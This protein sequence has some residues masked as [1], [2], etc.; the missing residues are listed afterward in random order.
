MTHL[1]DL[2]YFFPIYSQIFT[3]FNFQLKRADFIDNIVF[4]MR[5]ILFFMLL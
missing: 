4:D 3:K 5:L 2:Y 1:L